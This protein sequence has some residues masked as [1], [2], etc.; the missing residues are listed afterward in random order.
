GKRTLG[1]CDTWPSPLLATPGARASITSTRTPF[2]S[3]VLGTKTQSPSKRMRRVKAIGRAP[4][5]SRAVGYVRP[6]VALE[7]APL[8][9]RGLSKT[10]ALGPVRLA[11]GNLCHP[12]RS[13]PRR[14]SQAVRSADRSVSGAS[15]VRG[16]KRVASSA[17][18]RL[19]RLVL[20]DR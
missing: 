15:P 6:L 7:S 16:R 2:F 1:T 5:T 4:S 20:L 14:G 19:V 13:G 9:G 12:D 11:S 10:C 17:G 3:L 18:R 8:L